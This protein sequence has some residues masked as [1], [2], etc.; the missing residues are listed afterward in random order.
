MFVGVSC[1]LV[2]QQVDVGG[3]SDGGGLA[4]MSPWLLGVQGDEFRQSVSS[5]ALCTQPH[6]VTGM[7]VE[8]K[9]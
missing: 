2:E 4:D 3:G 8:D 9:S 5:V 7:V 1:E 6:P